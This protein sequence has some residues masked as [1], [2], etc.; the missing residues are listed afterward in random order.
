MDQSLSELAWTQQAAGVWERGIDEVEM[1]WAKAAKLFD[2]NGRRPF[3]IT[4]HV[5]IEMDIAALTGG[6]S[7]PDLNAALRKAWCSIRQAHPSIASQADYDFDTERFTR[8]YHGVQNDI[9]REAWLDATFIEIS[10]GQTGVE[11][12]NSDPPAPNLP[13][14]FIITPPSTSLRNDEKHLRRDVI[15][16]APHETIDGVGTLLLLN[17]FLEHASEALEQGAS[18]AMPEFIGTEVKNLSPPY[19]IA[20]TIPDDLSAVLKERVLRMRSEHAFFSESAQDYEKRQLL[21]VPF[22]QGAQA[23]GRHQRVE[24]TLDQKATAKIAEACRAIKVTVTHAFNAAIPIAMRD[25]QDDQAEEQRLYY[26]FDLLRNL[27]PFCK[28]PFNTSQHPVTA[29][30]SGSCFA[31]DIA[32]HTSTTKMSEGSRKEEFLRV[33]DEVRVFYDRVSNDSDHQYLVPY[34][35]ANWLERLPKL[36]RRP[37]PGPPPSPSPT[38]TLS[39]L[40]RVDDM[41]QP[42]MKCFNKTMSSEPFLDVQALINQLTLDEKVELLAGQGSFRTTGLPHRGIPQ[43]ITSDGPHGIRGRRSFTRN[44][45][46]MLPS[47]TGMGAT[48]DADLLHQVGSLL[49]EEAKARGV[50]VLLA[51]TICLQ[52]SPL[53]GRGFEAFGEDPILSGILGAR[54]INGVQEHGVATSVK[55]YAA[56]D[57][58]DNCIEDNVIMTERTLREVHLLPFQ[59]TLRDSDPWTFMTSYNKINGTHASEDPLLLKKILRDEWGFKGLVMSDWFGTYST[60]ESINAGMDLEMPGP[61]DW[62]GKR[63]SIAVNSRKVSRETVNESVRKVLNLVNQVKAGESTGKP[64]VSNSPEQRALIR[65]LVSEGIVLLKNDQ[66]QLPIENPTKKKFGLIG[67]HV[68]NPALCGGGSAEVEPYYAVTPYDAIVEVVGE[69]NVS[70]APGCYSFRFSPLLKGLTPPESEAEGWFVEIFGENPNENTNAKAVVTTIAE[71]QLVDV[72]ESY[73]KS[74]PEMYYVRARARYTVQNSGLFRFG[75]STSGKGKLKI[76]GREVIDLWTHQPPKTE[77]T[78]CF[79]RLSME[80]FYDIE[81]TK[82]Q[83]L[84]LEVLQVNEDLAGGVGTALTLT[85]RVGGYEIFDED[86]GIK[87]AAELARNVD[88][89][90]VVTGLSSDYEYEGADRKNLR[91]PGRVDE[92]IQAVL[93]ANPKA[94][95]V[96]QSG[97]PIE[98][99]WESQAATLLHAWFGGQ[100]TGHGIADIIFGKVNPSGRLS[101]TFPKSIKHTPAYLTFSKADYDI[102]YGEGV[103]IGHRY[104]E[105]VDRD[106]LFY[107]GHGLSYST[108]EFARLQVPH[109]FPSLADH[110]MQISVDVTN[111]GPYK[112]AEVVQ[113]YI[114]DPESSVQRPVRELKAFAK[115]FLEVGEAKTVNLTLDKYSLSFWSQEAS[116]WKAEAG[117]YIVI[118]ATS[119]NPKDE[120]LRSSFALQETFFWEGL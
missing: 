106:P 67:D 111:K 51:P 87:D 77:S 103:Y 73:H 29:Y 35:W 38:A 82:G 101:L 66:K 69:E 2:S 84:N 50:H 26:R 33:L 119:S 48:F 61:T 110:K 89:P 32:M 18:S 10:N 102:V 97:L 17:N 3:E 40:G 88:V 114:H 118:I 19:R 105:A 113:V 23:P 5:S 4:G 81:V 62:R 14:I 63:L 47:A 85:G 99:P 15:L 44:P 11:F 37:G 104:Y 7:P 95:I 21:S 45:S 71:K 16:R 80:K 27:R 31:C 79:N 91:L 42:K 93:S 53:I 60:S 64:P 75:F 43:L 72:P 116:K 74:I 100:E 39:S 36:E 68:K 25:L 83:V 90:I 13:T 92:L 41:I 12:A 108:F 46:P 20:A 8:S 70:Y 78:A 1:F 59:L 22:K 6:S 76:D 109:E 107:F 49:G 56:H 54:Y 120:A 65:R 52:R 55:H 9:E 115:V 58:S 28:E 117:E 94:I 96:T 57:Q 112:G 24:I 34:V 30:H 86:Q 98:M